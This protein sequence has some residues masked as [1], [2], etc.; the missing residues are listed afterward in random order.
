[1]YVP[2]LRV[3][4]SVLVPPL[5]VGVAP[6]VFPL[7][8]CWIV[9]LWATDD[10][11]AK[12][13]VTLPALADSE[14]FVNLSCPVGLAASLSV[15]EP[16]PPPLALAPPELVDDVELVDEAGADDEVL[17]LL[18]ELPQ[19]ATPTARAATLRAR[20]EILGK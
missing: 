10:M 7:V 1:M 6:T 20:A 8:P 2:G 15:L 18:L 3:T 9:M 5:N 19:A 12:W 14:S 17:L 16:P 4:L 11:L 13:I